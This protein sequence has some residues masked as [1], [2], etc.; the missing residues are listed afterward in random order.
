MDSKGTNSDVSMIVKFTG[1]LPD[2][3]TIL[4]KMVDENETFQTK[5]A[6]VDRQ[7]GCGSI[8][9]VRILN[10]KFSEEYGTYTVELEVAVKRAFV[11][12]AHKESSQV[13]ETLFGQFFASS[14]V[15][16]KLFVILAEGQKST[17]FPKQETFFQEG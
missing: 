1:I 5:E 2:A 6:Y 9:L 8:V 17:F 14:S 12:V 11:M 10:T 4:H 15:L 3:M 13:E 16:E 7:R